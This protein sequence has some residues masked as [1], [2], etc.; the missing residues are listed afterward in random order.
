MKEELTCELPKSI[1]N[2]RVRNGPLIIL[3]TY[4][5]GLFVSKLK[6]SLS[7]TL[8]EH[9][10]IY[11]DCLQILFHLLSE[12]YCED[13]ELDTQGRPFCLWSHS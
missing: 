5:V 11:E 3:S 10:V 2:F 1:K 9:L 12:S 4:S 8:C 7:L 6:P 13:K